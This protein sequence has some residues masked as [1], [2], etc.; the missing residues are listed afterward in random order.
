MAVPLTKAKLRE[1]LLFAEDVA[2]QRM[3]FNGE[4]ISYA[5]AL[6]YSLLPGSDPEVKWTPAAVNEF[7]LIESATGV[8]YPIPTQGLQDS[9]SSS[10]AEVP[11]WLKKPIEFVDLTGE[12]N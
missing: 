11:M 10:S 2:W 9:S 4:D 5:D 1:Y 8:V 7:E 6:V 3:F 12:S